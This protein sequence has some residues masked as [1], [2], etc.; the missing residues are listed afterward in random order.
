MWASPGDQ[1]GE[2]FSRPSLQSRFKNDT[3]LQ[4]KLKK[5][6]TSQAKPSSKERESG[7]FSPT[8]LLPAKKIK[9]GNRSM[10]RISIHPEDL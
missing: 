4:H 9:R 6:K 5:S 10:N 1:I 8:G 2:Q 3:S 7:N